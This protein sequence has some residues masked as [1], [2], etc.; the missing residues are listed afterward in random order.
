MRA[1]TALLAAALAIATAGPALAA[2]WQGDAHHARMLILEKYKKNGVRPPEVADTGRT[3]RAG[4]VMWRVYRVSWPTGGFRHV[5]VHR[6]RNGEYLAIEGLEK[7]RKWSHGI[8][9]GR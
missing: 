6:Q 1:K 2:D 7:E 9:I 8:Q 5:A 4:G 3:F